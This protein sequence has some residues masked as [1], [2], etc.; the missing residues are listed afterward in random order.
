MRLW[1]GVP[2][3]SSVLAAPLPALSLSLLKRFSRALRTWLTAMAQTTKATA[4][5][6]RKLKQRCASSNVF[7]ENRWRLSGRTGRTSVGCAASGTRS[8]L[9]SPPRAHRRAIKIVWAG[10]DHPSI[11]LSVGSGNPLC[12]YATACRGAYGLFNP[13]YARNPFGRLWGAPRVVLLSP[14]FLLTRTPLKPST[15]S[16]HP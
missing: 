5:M 15:L 7:P 10:F 1:V 3:A 16:L 6:A 9:R 13:V 14:R 11:T 12:A 8:S 4:P 2:G